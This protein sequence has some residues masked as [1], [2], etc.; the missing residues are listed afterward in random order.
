[1]PRRRLVIFLGLSVGVGAIYVHR[2]TRPP[3]EPLLRHSLRAEA[4]GC[5]ALFN[6]KRRPIDT[7][8]YNAAPN[9]QLDSS[10]A[11][12]VDSILGEFRQM[13]ALNERWQPNRST[14]G[15]REPT[16][17]ADSLSDTVRL[18]FVN[19]LSGAEFVLALPQAGTDTLRG[20]AWEH[21]D[22]GPPYFTNRGRAFAVRV[23]CPT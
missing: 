12:S 19:G 1:M 23:K 4:V 3:V 7:T 20:H 14:H 2:M 17:S 5:Y 15:L 22:F 21:W 9:V 13:V 16:W 11:R 8:Y 18:S 6:S 10:A